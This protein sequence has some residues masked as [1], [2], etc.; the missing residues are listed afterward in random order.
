M[1]VSEVKELLYSRFPEIMEAEQSILK[2]YSTYA[3]N[4]FA[5]WFFDCSQTITQEGFD[6]RAYQ[7][8]LLREDFHRVHGSLQ[9]NFYCYFLCEEQLFL[10]IQEQ[11]L[12]SVVENDRE[13]ARKFVR[14]PSMLRSE[15]ASLEAISTETESALPRDVGSLWQNSLEEQGLSPVYSDCS[16]A[17]AVRHIK[18]GHHIEAA[19]TDEV[20]QVANAEPAIK[21]IE[22]IELGSF[23]HRPEKRRFQFGSCNL[24]SGVNGSGK[25]SLLEAIEAWMCGKHRR[26]PSEA[27]A[28]NCL[29]LKIEGIADWQYGPTANV[30]LY[31]QRDHE[32]YGN[33]Q[34][35]RNDLCFNFARFSFYDSDAAAR[36]EISEDDREIQTALS[37][38][39]LGVAATRLSERISRLL[40]VLKREEREYSR[41]VEQSEET[42]RSAEATINA[43][44]KP[45]DTRKQTFNKIIRQLE[46]IRWR[47]ALPSDSADSCLQLLND[48]NKIIANIENILST[49]DWLKRPTSADLDSQIEPITLLAKRIDDLTAEIDQ[50]KQEMIS[51][52]QGI[53]N[54]EEKAKLFSRWLEY[55]EAGADQLPS[56]SDSYNRALQKRESLLVAKDL[57][58]KVDLQRYAGIEEAVTAMF[59]R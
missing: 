6:L 2:A 13:Y 58:A 46:A 35:R 15:L 37:R 49:L 51:L 5:I 11:G 52:D 4:P 8:Q 34:A 1:N 30:A 23:R 32:W 56:I 57:I 21:A 14:T 24:I 41:R 10:K 16:Y 12:V 26:N 18:S 44:D 59:A 55:S 47:G 53:S 17:D 38:L 27:I 29:R 33:Y 7:D 22:A 40:P 39:I 42:I 19:E 20:I 31:R 54:L 43:L 9:W 25:T 36:F 45:T 28:N 3:G 50:A 48:T